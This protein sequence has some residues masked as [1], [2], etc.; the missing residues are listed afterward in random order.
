M[1]FMSFSKKGISAAEMQR[2][3]DHTRYETVWKLVHKIRCSMGKRDCDYLLQ[4][5][6]EF[7]EGFFRS[8][9]EKRLKAEQAR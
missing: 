3:L 2:Q 6:Y 8:V 1:P 5:M 9:P 4:G 7:D